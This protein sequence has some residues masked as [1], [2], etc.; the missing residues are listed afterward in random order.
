MWKRSLQK[1]SGEN[2]QLNREENSKLIQNLARIND[3]DCKKGF[4]N[5]KKKQE[6][7]FREDYSQSL[8]HS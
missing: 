4:Q 3:E 1:Y 7:S 2:F 6:I 5:T 8:I